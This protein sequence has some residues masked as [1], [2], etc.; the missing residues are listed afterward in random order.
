MRSLLVFLIACSQPPA[1][2]LA[3]DAGSGGS[4]TPADAPPSQPPPHG[5][6]SQKIDQSAMHVIWASGPKDLYVGGRAIV[7]S[8]GDGTWTLATTNPFED[9]NEY[10]SAFWGSS[11]TD[12]FAVGTEGNIE[13]TTGDGVWTEMTR[14]FDGGGELNAIYG[15]GPNDIYA[16]GEQPNS[17][18][19]VWHYDGTSW[20]IEATPMYVDGGYS[21]FGANAHDIWIGTGDGQIIHSTGDGTWQL[22]DNAVTTQAGLYAMWGTSATDIYAGGEG[23]ALI[24]CDGTHWSTRP[25][26][27]ST[28]ESIW[29]P[30]AIDGDGLVKLDGTKVV[31]QIVPG[32]AT[33]FLSVFGTSASDVDVLGEAGVDDYVIR[34]P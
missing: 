9:H 11:A 14:P 4:D 26:L 1:N 29:G 21:I 16:V 33:A 22:V 6:E 24:H 32:A 20:S 3:P 23:G 34:G 10:V 15:F 31:T 12:V 28:I 18:V 8:T 7:H 27:A 25:S 13:H 17:F 5:W 19:R 30:Y 2:E